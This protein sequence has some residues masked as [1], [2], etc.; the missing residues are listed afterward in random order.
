MKGGRHANSGN[1]GRT[2]IYATDLYDVPYTGIIQYSGALM[3][4]HDS[5]SIM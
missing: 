3:Q 2:S 4:K 5:L 1:P